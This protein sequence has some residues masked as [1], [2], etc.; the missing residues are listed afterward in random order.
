MKR[1]EGKD[2]EGIQRVKEMNNPSWHRSH[3]ERKMSRRKEVT[4]GK[5]EEKE[6][7]QSYRG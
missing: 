4:E 3:S 6:V 1:N 2:R 5:Q 7:E